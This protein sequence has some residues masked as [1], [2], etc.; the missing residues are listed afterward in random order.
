MIR[1]LLL[2]ASIAAAQDRGADVFKQSCAVGYCH[3]SGGSANRAP[4]LA[5]RVFDRAKL[6]TAVENG[7]PNT[8]MPGFAKVLNSADLA[9]VI[10][11]VA[12]LG[13]VTGTAG[14]SAAPAPAEAMPTAA[15]RGKALFFDPVRGTRCGTCHLVEGMGTAVG[16]NLASTRRGA[17]DLR[18]VKAEH[19]QTAA[20]GGDRFPAIV[21]EKK[22]EWVKLYDLT[23]SP[24]VLRT[25]PS[26]AVTFTAAAWSHGQAIASYTDG[27]LKAVADY[28]AWLASR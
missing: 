2:V 19:V 21:V 18:S 23:S 22:G 7:I 8:A 6:R 11:Y 24:P 5:G 26:A 20:A 17:P 9:A 13:A 4:R 15:S 28:L 25:L 1:L 27:D 12:G 3:G 16:P 14:A 10:E